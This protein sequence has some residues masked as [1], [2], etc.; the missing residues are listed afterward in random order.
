MVSKGWARAW[1]AAV[2]CLAGVAA[3]AEQVTLVSY[4]G[5]VTLTGE[6]L[7]FDGEKY[8]VD[9]TI[10][11]IS[12]DAL[13]V[14]CEG[15]GCPDPSLLSSEFELRGSRTVGG[16]L[17]PA[18]VTGYAEALEADVIQTEAEGGMTINLRSTQGEPECTFKTKDGG[19]FVI[20]A[21]I[22]DPNGKPNRTVLSRGVAGGCAR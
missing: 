20:V 17:M 1:L 12:I 18:I 13:Q 11:E 5:A 2:L 21:T 15:P 8:R 14:S 19:T 10:G 16:A 9:T 3:T 4:D 6:L 7:E 22:K